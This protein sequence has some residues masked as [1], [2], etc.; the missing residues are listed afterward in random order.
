MLRLPGRSPP[1]SLTLRASPR[2]DLRGLID[3]SAHLYLRSD[4]RDPPDLDA[5]C[6]RVPVL[7][8]PSSDR[9][10][11]HGVVQR[12]PPSSTSRSPRP[13]STPP[14]VSARPC[15]P[16]EMG[17]PFPSAIRPRGFSPPRRLSPPRR[18][19]HCGPLPILG[20][21]AFHSVARRNSPRCAYCPSKLSLRR[22]LRSHGDES[23]C[24]RGL[25]SPGRP[26]P[27]VPFTANLAPSSFFGTSRRCSIFGSV[28]R[29]A[30]S[31]RTRPVLPWACPIRPVVVLF[32]SSSP[33]AA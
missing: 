21:I 19:G 23:P 1:P 13:G 20:F 7:A 14:G 24:L 15:R 4:A 10:S 8:A 5:D 16:I 9:A 6:R 26:S 18:C 22:Q 31:S 27:I 28:A 32:A 17:R 25:A 3:R 12:S 29:P 33:R 11:S 2:A 30:V